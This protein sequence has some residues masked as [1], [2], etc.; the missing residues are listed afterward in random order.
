MFLN[1]GS[2]FFCKTKFIVISDEH[3]KKNIDFTWNT[4]NTV[5]KVDEGSSHG[6]IRLISCVKISENKGKTSVLLKKII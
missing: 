5:T 1:R 6:V 4:N 3:S 2:F